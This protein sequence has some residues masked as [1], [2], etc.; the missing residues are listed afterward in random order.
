MRVRVATL[1]PPPIS[2]RSRQRFLPDFLR[3]T[4]TYNGATEAH[5]FS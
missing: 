2:S 3:V 4:I 5:D 1:A